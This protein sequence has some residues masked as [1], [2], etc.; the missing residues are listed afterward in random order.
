MNDATEFD[1]W[2]SLGAQ[3]AAEDER[4]IQRYAQGEGR[5]LDMR[6][7]RDFVRKV[8]RDLGPRAII[9]DVSMESGR[10]GCTVAAGYYFPDEGPVSVATTLPTTADRFDFPT[11]PSTSV[12]RPPGR[13]RP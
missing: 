6:P 9:C 2:E 11:L 4:L 10:D 12:V 5:G 7:V 8:R 3:R 1:G 13:G